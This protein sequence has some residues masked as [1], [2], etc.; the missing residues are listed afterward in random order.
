MRVLRLPDGIGDAPCL[1]T[2]AASSPRTA[3][4]PLMPAEAPALSSAN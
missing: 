2:L 1:T 3:V 4:M